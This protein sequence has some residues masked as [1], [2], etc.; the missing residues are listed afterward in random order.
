[1]GYR[2]RSR[3]VR[4]VALLVLLPRAAGAR[5]VA[6]DFRLRALHGGRGFLR[7]AGERQLLLRWLRWKC[8]LHALRLL[9][10]ALTSG[11]LDLPED[12]HD[13]ILDALQHRL[14][15]LE[16]LALVLDERIALAVATQSDAFLEV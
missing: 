8:A 5:I 14:E 15:Q 1:M 11:Q 16:R 2:G 13:A 4:A 9:T 6:A 10:V 12:L 3:R 7:R